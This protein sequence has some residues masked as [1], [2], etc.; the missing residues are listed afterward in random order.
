M[1]LAPRTG[2]GY[3]RAKP[4]SAMARLRRQHRAFQARVGNT[5][6]SGP[7]LPAKAQETER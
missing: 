6:P 1:S 3:R 4:G 7:A 2:P 5:V